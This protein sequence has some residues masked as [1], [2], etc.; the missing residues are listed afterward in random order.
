M[1]NA[2][3]RF[4]EGFGSEIPE[5]VTFFGFRNLSNMCY[6][7]SVLQALL[8][9]RHVRCYLDTA[10]DEQRRSHWATESSPFVEFLEIYA[11]RARTDSP[12]IQVRPN[13]FIEAVARETDQFPIGYQHDAH[14][15]ALFLI[16]S[17]DKTVNKLKKSGRI[18]SLM[19]FSKLFE[20]TRVSTY[21]CKVC[22]KT[23]EV[24][25]E[26]TSLDIAVVA[27]ED[28][29]EMLDDSVAPKEMDSDWKCDFCKEKRI[30]RVLAHFAKLPP[31]LMVQL[32]RFRYDRKTNS[33]AKLSQ[34]VVIP[35]VLYLNSE[36]GPQKY[37]LSSIIVHLGPSLRS[38]HF[39]T[40]IKE[41]NRW[42]LAND[43]QLSWISTNDV[44]QVLAGKVTDKKAAYVPYV[45]VYEC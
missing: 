32:Q 19:D 37:K 10:L 26:F 38:G 18:V 16:S 39:I 17:F 40:L 21:D 27:E 13:A 9:S 45:L 29:Q 23:Q 30:G 14:E 3:S 28:L 22:Q 4:V 12:V 34:F 33:M 35:E 25:E 43:D 6:C 24:R 11:K 31:I 2:E 8:F 5:G 36:T 42:V 1:G 44:N 20:G 15:F 7:N 41:C